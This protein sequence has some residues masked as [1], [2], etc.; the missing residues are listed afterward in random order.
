MP[1]I[2]VMVVDTDSVDDIID[3]ARATNGV[4]GVGVTGE[5]DDETPEAEIRSELW[6]AFERTADR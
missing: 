3:A 2:L 1:R 6:S 4:F 5:A